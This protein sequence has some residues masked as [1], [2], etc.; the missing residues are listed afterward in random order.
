VQG[1]GFRYYTAEEARRRHLA[2]WVRNLDSGEVEAVFQGTRLAVEDM[3]R[4]SSD[5]PPGAHVRYIRV[6]WDEPPE[7]L[8][9][10]TFEIHTTTFS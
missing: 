1:V 2:G 4:W 8:S 7:A 3:V 10:S 6:T 9:D 5:G